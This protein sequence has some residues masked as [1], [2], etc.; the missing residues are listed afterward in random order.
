MTDSS[1][2]VQEFVIDKIVPANGLEGF[3][4]VLKKTIGIDLRGVLY[5]KDKQCW[6]QICTAFAVRHL[7]EHRDG[8][9]DRKFREKVE[10]VWGESSWSR[11]TDIKRSK[12]VPVEEK[13]VDKTCDA[14]L[15][16]TGLLAEEVRR[17]SLRK[18][19][20][21]PPQVENTAP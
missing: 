21:S 10:Q 5:S 17:W 2:E 9:V 8:R 16:A 18:R 4:D 11:H 7:V 12:K 20:D 14:M 13:D 6:P 1:V 19:A 3:Q 15:E